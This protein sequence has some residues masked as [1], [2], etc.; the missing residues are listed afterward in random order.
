MNYIIDNINLGEILKQ[1]TNIYFNSS[2]KFKNWSKEE[3]SYILNSSNTT[4]FHIEEWSTEE[5]F[6]IKK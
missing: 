2:F 4:T 1:I 6:K 5:I 3:Y